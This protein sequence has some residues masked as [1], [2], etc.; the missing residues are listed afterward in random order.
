MSNITTNHTNY[1]PLG[2][3]TITN[4]SPL[5]PITITKQTNAMRTSQAYFGNRLYEMRER[6]FFFIL[7]R[8]N[9]SI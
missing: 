3:I 2:P 7:L 1:T 4:C 8:L 9:E 5:G 6:F